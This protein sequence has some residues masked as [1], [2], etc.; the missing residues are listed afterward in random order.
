MTPSF[1][2]IERLSLAEQELLCS[3]SGAVFSHRF[4]VEQA[5]IKM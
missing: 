2:C 5:Y 4:F 3:S 1:Y